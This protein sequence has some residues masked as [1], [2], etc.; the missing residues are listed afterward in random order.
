MK[1]CAKKL[2]IHFL[3]STIKYFLLGNLS[4]HSFLELLKGKIDSL[5]NIEELREKCIKEHEKELAS[6]ISSGKS[7][8]MESFD[9]TWEKM[10]KESDMDRL[11][12]EMFVSN[13]YLDSIYKSKANVEGKQIGSELKYHGF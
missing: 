2:E 1:W 11:N 3:P 6:T 4:K 8:P 13:S 5:H 7:V 9:S 10:M 12:V